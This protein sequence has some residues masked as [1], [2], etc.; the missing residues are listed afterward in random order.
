MTCEEGGSSSTSELHIGDG[1][2]PTVIEVFGCPDEV[3]GEFF[4]GLPRDDGTGLKK[5][6]KAFLCLKLSL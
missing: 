6:P 4:S 1:S 3:F 5:F 2:Y